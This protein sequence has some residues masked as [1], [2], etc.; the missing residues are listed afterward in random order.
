MRVPAPVFTS[1]GFSS[2]DRR[3]DSIAA[4]VS[5]ARAQD[6]S[7]SQV[8]TK[9]PSV[10]SNPVAWTMAWSATDADGLTEPSRTIA[11]MF[12]GNFAA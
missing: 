4:A 9:F 11:R 7:A 2:R 10:R 12:A 8:V 6:L 3:V 5:G 1:T